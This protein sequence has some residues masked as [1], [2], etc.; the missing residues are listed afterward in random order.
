MWRTE[1]GLQ[2]LEVEGLVARVVVPVLE[3]DAL[4]LPARYLLRGL[5]DD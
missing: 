4:P 3:R 1:H 5:H 2:A